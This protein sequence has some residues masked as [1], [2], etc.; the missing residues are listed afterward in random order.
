M[1]QGNSSKQ[2]KKPDDRYIL[3][4][5]LIDNTFILAYIRVYIWSKESNFFHL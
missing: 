3:V 4:N 1:E 2:I 5:I